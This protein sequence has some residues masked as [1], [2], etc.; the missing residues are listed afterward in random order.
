MVKL[1]SHCSPF[2]VMFL[3]W[4]TIVDSLWLH[5]SEDGSPW[6]ALLC[7]AAIPVVLILQRYIIFDTPLFKFQ[8]INFDLVEA[9]DVRVFLV[10]KLLQCLFGQNG[11]DPVDV[12]SPY[13]HLV[14]FEATLR[15]AAHILLV[16]ILR[17]CVAFGCTGYYWFDAFLILLLCQALFSF[18]LYLLDLFF[19]RKLKEI[20]YHFFLI[21]SPYRACYFRLNDILLLLIHVWTALR[22]HWWSCCSR[23]YW[24]W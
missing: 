10:Q 6:V 17:Q 5:L 2:L 16:V 20:G 4:E 21:F 18:T 1:Q 24:R 15:T 22:P 19:L 7:R 12:P 8:I 3:I 14:V 13:G 11:I 9:H 23:W